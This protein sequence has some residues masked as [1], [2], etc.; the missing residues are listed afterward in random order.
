MEIRQAFHILNIAETKDEELI[1]SAYLTLLGAVNPEDDAEGFMR[2][3]E[4]YE[5]ALELARQP[6][7]TDSGVTKEKTE[8]ELW[9]DAVDAVY[10]D[11]RKRAQAEVWKELF[12]NPA[13]QGLDVFMNARDK[14]LVYLMNHHNLPLAVWQ[15]ID[16]EFRILADMDSLKLHYPEN[17]L[18]YVKYYIQHEGFFNFDGFCPTGASAAESDADGYIGK[19]M[20]IKQTIDNHQYEGMWQQLDD[21]KAFG[22][23]HPD[24]DVLR[25][26]LLMAEER[27]DEAAAICD[28]LLEHYPEDHYVLTFTAEYSWAQGQADTAFSLWDKL[29]AIRPSS[30]AARDGLIKYYRQQDQPE[31]A[32]EYVLE[33]LKDQNNNE[34]MFRNLTEINQILIKQY[35]EQLADLSD[36]EEGR[37][38]RVKLMF[39]LGWCYFQNKEFHLGIELIEGIRP[40]PEEEWR[41]YN[42]LGRSFYSIHDYERALPCLLKLQALILATVDDGSEEA[43]SRLKKKAVTHYMLSWCRFETK[44]FEDAAADAELAVSLEENN[45]ARYYHHEGL[46]RIYIGSREYAKAIDAADRLLAELPDFYRIYLLRM[47]AAYELDRRQLVVDDYYR[48]IDIHADYFK[49]YL[50]AAKVFFEC[51][52]FQD[53]WSVLARAKEN[54]VTFSDQMLLYEVK[55]R[56]NLAKDLKDRQEAMAIC[57]QLAE[58]I[59]AR[60]PGSGGDQASAASSDSDE[61]DDLFEKAEI[62]FEIGVLSWDMDDVAEAH[63]WLKKAQEENPQRPNYFWA[64]GNL[65]RSEEQYEQ[66][67]EL[68]RQVKESYE[69]YPVY[70]QNCA[71]C[72]QELGHLDDA[73]AAFLKGAELDEQYPKIWENIAYLCIDKYKKSYQKSDHEEAVRYATK[74]LEIE[75]NVRYL[76][77]RGSVYQSGMLLE[78]AMA[79]YQRALELDPEDCIVYNDIGLCLMRMGRYDEAI[80]QLKKAAELVGDQKIPYPFNNLSS[81]YEALGDYETANEYAL[82]NIEINPA[83]DYYPERLARNHHHMEHYQEAID[84]FRAVAKRRGVPESVYTHNIGQAYF[85]MGELETAEK[86]Y[87]K[88]AEKPDATFTTV[89]NTGLFFAEDLKKPEI[90]ERYY[91]RSEQLTTDDDQ[92]R[93]FLRNLADFYFETGNYSKAKEYGERAYEAHLAPY[94]SEEVCFSYLPSR[95]QNLVHFAR[96]YLYIGNPE[97]AKQLLELAEQ[98]YRCSWCYRLGCTDLHQQWAMYYKSIKDWQ[99]AIR[100]YEAEQRIPPVKINERVKD[101]EELRKKLREL[102]PEEEGQYMK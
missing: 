23:Y 87:R 95:T 53:A 26:R 20:D 16:R 13:C 72:L 85:Q 76:L 60:N 15:V 73:L 92:K 24:E 35:K 21:L 37:E 64:E 22:I 94:G 88:M 10:R 54:K 2:L 75:E 14:L 28:C 66:A 27:M 51:S 89:F 97:K 67:L 31:K 83:S 56:R 44:Q 78:L 34:V 96:I 63:V 47:E 93:H 11:I 84:R 59:A 57:R 12:A 71:F 86:Y 61:L 49:P 55:T 5:K 42:Y 70:H 77:M 39:D 9:M 80:V 62:S 69:S 43:Q 65:Y 40:R 33:I 32:K 82:K 41:Y 102:E 6:N 98:G 46:I 4:A 50:L 18:N 100:E 58:R 19:L 29:L 79:D 36:S 48:A 38:Q 8:L 52:Q 25:L 7:E 30:Y 3:R 74:Q 45:S 90:A 91:L 81:C 99:G 101:I 17:F 68:Y 1:K